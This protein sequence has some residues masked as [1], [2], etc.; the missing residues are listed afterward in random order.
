MTSIPGTTSNKR[1]LSDWFTLRF[2][3]AANAG[4]RHSY[5]SI[6]EVVALFGTMVVLAAIPSASVALVVTRAITLGVSNG[7]AVGVGIVIGDLV[8]IGF[9]MFGLSFV[10]EA[11]GSM[12]VV[13]KYLGGIYLVWLGVSLL[14][15]KAS[16]AAAIDVSIQPSSFVVSFLV[17]L[18]L[19][20]GDAKAIFF[21]L[22]LLPMF[23]DLE[24]LQSS[25]V[26]IVVLVTIFAVGGT[27][28]LYALF[29]T[30]LVESIKDNK[31][32]TVSTSAAGAVL[33]GA[34]S[35]LIVKA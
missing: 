24:S 35:Y 2:K 30:Q 25:D 19:T 14:R 31:L 16:E 6:I 27:K 3:P 32:K 1:M 22:S 26:L 5:M 9:V 20:L 23:V 7:I 8:F 4:V 18:I 15:A 10:A 34:G 11:L 28:V 29:A 33:I 12:F 17:G 13:I 21:Y